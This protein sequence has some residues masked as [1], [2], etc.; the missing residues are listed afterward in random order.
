MNLLKRIT[1][2]VDAVNNQSA[3]AE[4]ALKFIHDGVIITDKSGVIQFINPA[5]ATMTGNTSPDKAM[6]L[7]YGLVV[8][9][10]SKEGRTLSDEENPLIQ[11]IKTGQPLEAFQGSLIVGQS[12]KRIPI[13]ISV[14]PTEGS[15]ANHIITFPDITKELEEEGEQS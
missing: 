1:K 10:E 14:L 2:P 11:A 15:N 8:R 5:A 6:G 12:D 3:M 7:D 13:S 4:M 9:L